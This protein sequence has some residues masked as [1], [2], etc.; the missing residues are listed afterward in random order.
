LI[1]DVKELVFD[2]KGGELIEVEETGKKKAQVR[3]PLGLGLILQLTHLLQRVV[4]KRSTYNLALKN[5]AVYF[6][7]RLMDH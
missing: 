4:W 7:D 5:Q 2:F 3:A 1:D 6:Q